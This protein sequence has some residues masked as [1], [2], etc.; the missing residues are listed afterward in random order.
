MVAL[1]QELPFH[2]HWPLKFPGIIHMIH[3]ASQPSS[4]HVVLFLGF[5]CPVTLVFAE[6]IRGSRS[7]GSHESGLA[8][9]RKLLAFENQ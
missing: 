4:L 6:K 7:V 9:N 1:D 5:S 8:H 3:A 2:T